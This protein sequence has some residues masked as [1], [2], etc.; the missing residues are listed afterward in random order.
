[1]KKFEKT[2]PNK[3]IKPEF[4]F[5]ENKKPSLLTLLPQI[6][7]ILPKLNFQSTN[8]QPKPKIP[9]ATQNLMHGENTKIAIKSMEQH[10]KKVH[11]IK[12]H[13]NKN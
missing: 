1:M 5:E 8:Q 10:Q 9:Y 4:L 12:M 11:E 2:P 3:A 13:N 7:K 6:L